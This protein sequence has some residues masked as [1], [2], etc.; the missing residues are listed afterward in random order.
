MGYIQRFLAGKIERALGRSPVVLITG[1]R[2]TG[3]STLAKEIGKSRG[4]T[5]VSFDD[6][7]VF[8]AAKQDPIQFIAGLQKPVI[9]DEI[10]RVPEIFLTIKKDVD[11]YREPG[12]YILTGSA[13][14]LLI[15]KLGD[16]LAGRMEIYELFTLSQ[17]ELSGKR[18][19]FIER[20]FAQNYEQLPVT[21]FERSELYK[22]MVTG[23][24]PSVQSFDEEGR[25]Q[26]FQS[27]RTTLLERDIKELAHIERMSQFPQLLSLLATRASS[28]LNVS[29]IARSVQIPPSTLGRYLS[30]LEVIYLIKLQAPW[31][32]NLG[33]RFTQA[34]KLYLNDTGLLS[35]LL[36]LEVQKELNGNQ[37][38]V[39]G[40]ILEN[41][42]VMELKKQ[43]GWST[44]RVQDFHFRADTTEVD[45]ILE[46][47]AGRVV[48]LEIK[49]ANTVGA[50][51]FKALKELRDKL[52]DRFIRGIVLYT[53]SQVIPFGDKLFAVPIPALWS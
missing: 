9:L 22:R 16:S 10:Q 3:K 32:V 29:D 43:A 14:P 21:L 36:N 38:L 7:S 33:K 51:D 48:A 45:I 27:Y 24:Y 44:V 5:Y 31:S 8:A 53:G 28:L 41:F 50:Q 25:T 46:G 35:F 12:R 52:G 13:N 19:H 39:M 30:W 34:P 18:E 1:A 47:P 42:V 17:G 49:H 11:D 20:V 23:G 15:P 2:Q 4:Y 40:G 26:W 6:I 37:L